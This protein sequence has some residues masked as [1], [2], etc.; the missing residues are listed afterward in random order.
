MSHR[1]DLTSDLS[2]PLPATILIAPQTRTSTHP[3]R[4]V[5]ILMDS[6]DLISEPSSNRF[7]ATIVIAPQTRVCPNP[8]H[9]VSTLMDRTDLI[10]DLPLCK[11]SH[12]FPATTVIV[13][14]SIS[15]NPERTVSILVDRKDLTDPYFTKKTP[16]A[17]SLTRDDN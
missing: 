14:Q 5:T 2:L 6:P 16:A 8:E 13:Q 12:R 7:P 3:E 10:S 9:T 15:T 4:T 17:L 11:F 1:I